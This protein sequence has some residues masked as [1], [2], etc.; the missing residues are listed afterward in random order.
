MS[1]DGK[2]MPVWY[3]IREAAEYLS[4]GEQTI[5]RWMR[6][7]KLTY[8]KIGDSTRFLRRD[9]D[10]MIQV[11]HGETGD[12]DV[13]IQRCPACGGDDLVAGRV[14]GTGLHYF[15]PEKARFWTLKPSMIDTRAKMCAQ[16]G[17][18]SMFGDLDHL[19]KLRDD[20]GAAGAAA[21]VDDGPSVESEVELSGDGEALKSPE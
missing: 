6:E 9:L 16:C 7:G 11:Y 14:R 19:H 8:R 15:Q 3:T 2:P 18:L 12:V 17:Y 21:A 4:V 1:S 10:G 13:V 20:Q 5:Y